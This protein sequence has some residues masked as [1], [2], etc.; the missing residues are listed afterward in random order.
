MVSPLYIP[1]KYSTPRNLTVHFSQTLHWLIF[2]EI[3][4]ISWEIPPCRFSIYSLS[5][6]CLQCLANRESLLMDCDNHHIKDSTTMYNPQSNQPAGVS[7]NLC[8]FQGLL[9]KK[10]S[11]KQDQI[12]LTPIKP[13]IKPSC[14]LVIF[15][16]KP[17]AQACAD[18]SNGADSA[19]GTSLTWRHGVRTTISLEF[20]TP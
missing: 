5:S 12:S 10:C 18:L 17:N 9:W 4:P 8:S 16:S 11:K 2:W 13:Y 19:L 15:W 6:H 1:T 3:Y 20:L 7:C 14:L